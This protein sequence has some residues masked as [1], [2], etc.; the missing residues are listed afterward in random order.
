MDFVGLGIS[1]SV[2]IATVLKTFEYQDTINAEIKDIDSVDLEVREGLREFISIENLNVIQFKMPDESGSISSSSVSNDMYRPFMGQG[3][4]VFLNLLTYVIPQ[5]PEKFYMIF[6]FD[7]I[8]GQRVRYETMKPKE[9]IGFL[10]NRN[11][12][13]LWLYDIVNKTFN[14][15]FESP[16]I[17]EVNN[18]R[19]A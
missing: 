4:S 2:D 7:W 13:Y 9:M 15:E 16:L 11:S 18:H 10:L 1:S 8:A 3:E 19:E 12:W 6:A 17:I 14:I 5:L